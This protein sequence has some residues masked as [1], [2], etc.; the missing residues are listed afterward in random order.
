[1]TN[2][3]ESHNHAPIDGEARHNHDINQFML[4][5]AQWLSQ[6]WGK[7]LD[8]F[9]LPCPL[10]RGELQFQGVYRDH[11]YEF[12]EGEPGIIS[13]LDVLPVSFVCNRCGYTAEFD[14]DLF[15]PAFLAQQWGAEAHHIQALTIRD[16]SILIPLSGH[17]ESETLLDLATGLAGTQAGVA[18]VFNHTANEAQELRL[19]EK[20]H[21]YIPSPGDP[22]PVLLPAERL[23]NLPEALA[24]V[25]QKHQ[26]DLLMIDVH[27]GK[28]ASQQDVGALI[29][30]VLNKSICDVAVVHNRG[31]KR[32]SRMLV[33]TAGGPNAK[34]AAQLA[35]NLAS[36]F[37]AEIHFLNVARPD[38]PNAKGEGQ[39]RIAETLHEVYIPDNVRFRNRVVIGSDPVQAIVQEASQYDVLLIGDSP[40]DW[41]GKVPQESISAKIARNCSST[42]LIVLGKNNEIQSWVDWLFG[43]N[44]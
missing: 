23:K 10:C 1:M 35:V 34:T 29:K 31:L 37:N 12:A 21:Q 9:R 4:R 14:S 25:A 16:Y 19:R 24:D 43:K 27:E 38:N 28:V 30:R 36:A 22:A 20:L 6:K 11:L 44:L 3:E 8:H 15:N 5:R 13:E 40:R 41:R 2:P 18:L 39:A 42:A 33:A 32:V 26:C 17:E 7:R